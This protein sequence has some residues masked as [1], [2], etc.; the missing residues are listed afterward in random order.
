M[1]GLKF[2]SNVENHKNNL[3]FGNVEMLNNNVSN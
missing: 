2:L 1:I 3:I